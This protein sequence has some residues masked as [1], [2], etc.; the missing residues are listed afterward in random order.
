M[1]QS[2]A[3]GVHEYGPCTD[4]MVILGRVELGSDKEAGWDGSDTKTGG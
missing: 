1:R 4:T 3:H 2:Q